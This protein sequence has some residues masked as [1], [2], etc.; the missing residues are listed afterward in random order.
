M[1]KPFRQPRAT[2]HAVVWQFRV[3]SAA[4]CNWVRLALVGGAMLRQGRAPVIYHFGKFRLDSVRETLSSADGPVPLRDH[5]LRV[6]KLLV[7]RAPEV[8]SKDEILNQVWGHESLSESSIAQV[9]KDIRQ[10]LGDSAKS[11]KLIATRY[12]RGYQFVAALHDGEAIAAQEPKRP[13]W[14]LIAAL[15]IVALLGTLLVRQWSP[16]ITPAAPMQPTWLIRAIDDRSG[17]SLSRAYAEY[18]GFVVRT[19]TGDNRIGLAKPDEV[20]AGARYLDVSLSVSDE[21]PEKRFQLK[22]YDPSSEGVPAPTYF[23]QSGPMLADSIERIFKSIKISP[24]TR[25]ESGVI[26]QSAFATETL[27]R[28]M[29]AQFDGDTQRAI[30]LFKAC[31]AEDD[32]FDFARYELAIALRRQG[33]YTQALALLKTLESRHSSDFWAYRI[34]N[35]KGI[36]HWRLGQYAEADASLTKAYTHSDTPNLRALIGTNLALLRR[37]QGQLEAAETSARAAIENA[38]EKRYPGTAA[39]AFNTLASILMRSGRLD[40]AVELLKKAQNLFQAQGN[41]AAYASVL[42]RTGDAFEQLGQYVQAEQ[43]YRLAAGIREQLHDELGVAA[44]QLDLA[45]LLRI[46]GDFS[47]SR[48]LAQSGLDVATRKGDTHL[49]VQGN[50]SLARLEASEQ[51]YADASVHAG[52]ALHLAKQRGE[53]ALLLQ[54]R[55]DLLAIELEAAP[56]DDSAALNQSEIDI[57]TLLVDATKADDPLQIAQSRLL[58][59]L[60]CVRRSDLNAARNH[61]SAAVELARSQREVGLQVRGL[62]ELTRLD[63]ADN[64]ARSAKHLADAE[65]LHPPVYPFAVLKARVFAAQGRQQ[66]AL[67]LANEAKL[68]SGDWWNQE[69]ETF[70]QQLVAD[71]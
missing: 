5:A 16:Q 56:V 37:D 43:H 21:D 52:E 28:G 1:S 7:E 66:T 18:L 35:T 67:A 65:K 45:R 39:S 62:I 3:L 30:A 40:E 54:A 44:S 20:V 36:A 46:R 15:A 29:A 25:I 60:A 59:G 17:E 2:V 51:R 12:A 6:L 32:D 50:A 49:M 23:G 8:I 33:E 47:Q 26:S 70:L 55:H 48:E 24:Q 4:L 57:D 38:D 22:L 34:E 10:A 64:P 41:R 19:A 42:S 68:T 14:R 58:R 31:L 61:F 71:K 69:D 53:P 9:V 11:P 13:R 63:L 27:L